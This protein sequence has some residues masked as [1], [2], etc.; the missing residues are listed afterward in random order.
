MTEIWETEQWAG[1]LVPWGISE[2]HVLVCWVFRIPPDRSRELRPFVR[3]FSLDGTKT[4]WCKNNKT[5]CQ[6][7]RRAQSATFEGS[8]PYK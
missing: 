8:V 4:N 5:V 7:G 1:W 3:S 2:C 6:S